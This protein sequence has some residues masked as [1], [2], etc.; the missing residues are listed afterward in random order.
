[1]LTLSDVLRKSENRL[2]GLHSL[3]RYMAIRLV[4]E[5]FEAGVPIIITQGFRG[6]EYQNQLFSQGRKLVN[7]EWQ[8]VDKSKIV[9]N[10]KGGRS[11]HNYGLA[12]DF[13]L[14][15]PNG[16][17]ASWDTRRDGDSDGHKDWY[18]VA[19]I[20]KRIFQSPHGE[21]GGDWDR[22]CDLPHFQYSFGLTID[23]LQHGMKAKMTAE[24]ANKFIET[25]LQPAW[26]AAKEK[27][28]Q[29]GMAQAA[30]QADELRIISGQK[31]QNT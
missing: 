1:M 17:T 21:W 6:I 12:V 15:L 5:S 10:A 11:F 19:D 20:G 26:K 3:V 30:K 23:Q 14:L 2:I 4:A 13:A 27:G 16:A 22:F 29:E 18:E 8:V 28:D 9:T 25:Q 7:G 24:A 31:P